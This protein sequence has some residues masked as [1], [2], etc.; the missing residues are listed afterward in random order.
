LDID[1][2]EDEE[3]TEPPSWRFA[4]YRRQFGVLAQTGLQSGDQ[5]AG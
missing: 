5:S 2:L 1:A 4:A 3:E